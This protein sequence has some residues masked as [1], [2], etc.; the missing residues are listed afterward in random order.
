[1]SLLLQLLVKL[2]PALVQKL[3]TTQPKTRAKVG[4]VCAHLWL[5]GRRGRGAQYT[6]LQIRGLSIRGLQATCLITGVL[7]LLLLLL[8]LRLLLLL[9]GA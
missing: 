2:L 6:C 8:P 7:L 9:S 5:A 3:S 1:M 4:P